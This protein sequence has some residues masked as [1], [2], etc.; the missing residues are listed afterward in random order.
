MWHSKI[1]SIL[2]AG[3]L[4]L[5]AVS[6]GGNGDSAEK[7]G[8][9]K[10]YWRAEVNNVDGNGGS[11]VRVRLDIYGNSV[12]TSK[13]DSL[14]GVINVA[15]DRSVYAPVAVDVIKSIDKIDGNEIHFS[16]VQRATGKEFSGVFIFNPTDKSLTF[17]S[18]GNQTDSA[19]SA[20]AY[21][22]S[23]E[24]L[25]FEF[26]NEK[27]NFKNVPL[28]DRL[29]ELPDRMYYRAVIADTAVAQPF[30]DNQLHCYYTE[31]D[32]DVK[33]TNE[34]G[35][36][37]FGA[38]YNSTIVDC[39]ALPEE[40]G[41]MVI[42][43][44]GSPRY[45]EF[46]CFRVDDSNILRDVDYVIGRRPLASGEDGAPDPS[47]VASMVRNGKQVRVY[48]PQM[49]ETRIYDLSGHRH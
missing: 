35:I 48:D 13:L 21:P 25:V 14:I 49:G 23:R 12:R 27:P 26:M 15:E 16:Y 34:I 1:Y 3:A 43:T 30:G 32:R 41:L 40:P 24:E 45:Q 9:F 42:I 6:C 29:L 19:E 5:A 4:S 31:L 20:A 17:R 38:N 2:A 8:P 36:S 10:G 46:A 37:P 11:V 33:I 7:E 28:S 47:E 18:S 39:W 44:S 22:F